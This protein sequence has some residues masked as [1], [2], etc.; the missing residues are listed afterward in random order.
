[1][2]VLWVTAILLDAMSSLIFHSQGWQ[3]VETGSLAA[4]DGCS[5]FCAALS[6]TVALMLSTVHSMHCITCRAVAGHR[7]GRPPAVAI[8]FDALPSSTPRAGSLLRL[9]V[10]QLLM[11]APR[12]GQRC[13]AL[14]PLYLWQCT[15][16]PPF[17]LRLQA[18]SCG[19]LLQRLVLFC[20]SSWL[21]CSP[22]FSYMHCPT[23]C[24]VSRSDWQS[25]SGWQLVETGSLAAVDARCPQ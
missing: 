9:A 25:A 7:R 21:L 11:V 1:V 16:S 4:V 24:I 14:C 15:I 13:L 10:S 5:T 18:C 6:S 20:V 17:T 8:L 12:C 3:L 23:R 22:G 2:A 19:S